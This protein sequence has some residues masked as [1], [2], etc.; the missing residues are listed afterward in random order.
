[1]SRKFVELGDSNGGNGRKGGNIVFVSN[2]NFNT[3]L[4]FRYGKHIKAGSGKSGASRD[5]SGTA[6]KTLYLK[7]QLA[8]IIDEE[9]EE[10]IAD[11]NKPDMECLTAQGKKGGPL[12]Y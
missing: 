6:G 4:N 8:P 2:A 10:V 12:G 1:M 9:S 5:K 7:C 3:L 11:F